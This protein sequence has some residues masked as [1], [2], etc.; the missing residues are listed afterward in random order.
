[1]DLNFISFKCV[2]KGSNKAAHLLATLGSFCAEAEEQF[3]SFIPK[4]VGVIVASD[5]LAFE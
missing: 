1:M 3:S 4:S 2:F 5:L